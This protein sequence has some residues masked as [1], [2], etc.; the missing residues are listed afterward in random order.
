VAMQIEINPN[1]ETSIRF[2][3][4]FDALPQSRALKKALMQALALHT[5]I[6]GWIRFMSGMS[7]K[8]YRYLINALIAETPDPRYLEV[9]SWKG[10]TACA[11][12]FQNTVTACC[13]DNWDPAFG[14]PKAEFEQNINRAL[15]P[16]VRFRSIDSDFRAVDYGALGKFN[17]YLFDGPHEEVDQYDGVMVAQPALDDIYTLIV[18]DW[19]WEDVRK[20]TQ[21]A[22]D[23][24]N[25]RVV[26]AIEV[27][28]TQDNTHSAIFTKEFSDWH[29]GY[30]FF[31]CAKT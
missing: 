23:Q 22:L 4:D 7:G 24:L 29:N 31:V 12:I 5:K 27:R 15:S 28:T 26:S 21:R 10:S 2:E 25:T 14:V 6:P 3:G 9:G 11:A 1:E 8:K 13:I 20:G 18:D 17:V 19:N 30:C 16:S